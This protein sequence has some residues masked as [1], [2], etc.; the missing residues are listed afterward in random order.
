MKMRP[1]FHTLHRSMLLNS[2][3]PLLVIE[4]AL[5]FLY[6]YVS[7]RTADKAQAFLQAQIVAN[8]EQTSRY[9]MHTIDLSLDKINHLA[10]LVSNAQHRFFETLDECNV[11]DHPAD[12][13]TTVEG[14]FYKHTNDGGTTL[15]LSSQTKMT[16]AVRKKAICSQIL[17]AT[18]KQAVDN[19]QHVTQA[20]LNTRDN[21]VRIYPF[22][23]N[24]PVLFGPS[25]K[26]LQHNFY[27]EADAA[28]NPTGD[29]VWTNAYLDPAGQG[30]MVSAIFPIKHNGVLEG[31]GGLD[32][33]LNQFVQGMLGIDLPKYAMALM[34]GSDGKVIA[35]PKQAEAVLGLKEVESSEGYVI[36]NQATEKPNTFNLLSDTSTDFYKLYSQLI[37]TQKPYA[38]GELNN[39]P[40]FMFIN[41][42]AHTDWQIIMLVDKTQALAP[43]QYMQVFATRLGW[44]AI[45]LV[46]I[47]YTLF[48]VFI[49]YKSA[50]LANTVAHPLEVLSEQTKHINND[51][52]LNQ[53][54][55][56]DIQE[57]HQ[58]NKNFYTMQTTLQS[59]TNELVNAEVK[60]RLSE[61]ENQLLE[62]LANTDTLT[63][64][65]NRL[66]MEKVLKQEIDLYLRYRLPF[67]VIMIDIDFFKQVNDGFGHKVGDRVLIEC[68]DTLQENL[69]KTDILGRW[70]GEEFI[71]V[72]RH[73]TPDKSMLVAEK[74]RAA[75]EQA[76]F[77]TQKQLTISL[78]V[79]G[80]QDNET[81]E[82]LIHRA[83]QALYQ[84][85]QQGRNQ[86]VVLPGDDDQ[87]S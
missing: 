32:I 63:Q 3:I 49:R 74:L 53:L 8:V 19:T 76:E 34:L 15:Y 5:L 33:T 20:Y 72:C 81:I 22:I 42:V 67:S 46:I 37:E 24:A 39:K 58:L 75:I 41:S 69:R 12:Y 52:A 11:A 27:Y 85:K 51:I 77:V 66:K 70:G 6:F 79:A 23:E 21:M 25:L 18:L 14:V 82:Q 54:A 64:V 35:M 86:Y 4:V 47:F 57:V 68:V 84:A 28:H 65:A 60:Q 87:H 2:L 59:R 29:I 50:K 26:L 16:A 38:E 78:G 83:D 73:S 56:T 31:V 71:V 36:V 40:Y 55:E 17:D 1:L 61:Q 9:K 30:W 43:V 48:F 44:L 62:T 45:L 13:R 7:H 80:Y 10:E